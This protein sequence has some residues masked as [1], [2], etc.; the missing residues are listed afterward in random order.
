MGRRP[1]I[2]MLRA[3]LWPLRGNAQFQSFYYGGNVLSD[4]HDPKRYGGPVIVYRAERNSFSYDNMG[5]EAFLTGPW[6]TV[7]V[8]GDHHTFL[9]EPH[10]KI[11]AR[12]LKKR[13]SFLL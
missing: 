12:D 11:L 13:L 6:E 10:V 4:V 9:R 2:R 8:T 1:L 3:G 7:R 5:W